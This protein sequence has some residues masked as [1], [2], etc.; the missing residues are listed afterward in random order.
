MARVQLALNV[1]DL[2]AAVAFYSD[3]FNVPVHKRRPGYANFVVVDPPLKL[4]LFETPDR[5]AGVPGAL[6]HIGVEVE[7]PAQVG[8]ADERLGSLGAKVRRGPGVVCCHAE[9]DKIW[10]DDPDDLEWE[11]YAVTDETPD[12]GAL[13]MVDGCC[14]Q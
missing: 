7:T 11:I 14:S 4:A 13:V 8:M 5:G 2:D 3:L 6:N 12:G 10:I 1:S 9:Q